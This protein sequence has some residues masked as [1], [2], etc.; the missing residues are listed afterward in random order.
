VSVSHERAP[1]IRPPREWLIP[2]G[3]ALATC[4][5]FGPVLQADFVSWDDDQNFLANPGYRGLGLDQLRWMWSTFHMGHYV[6]LTW[7]THGLDYAFWGMSP[8][9]YHA[10]NLALHAL[11]A[12]LLY[13]LGQRLVRLAGPD[14]EAPAVASSA[15]VAALFFAL[16]PLRVES[17][18]WVTERRDVLSLA[19]YLTAVLSYLRFA[20][21]HATGARRRWYT[22]AVAAGVC[23]VLSKGIAVTLP[24]VLFILNVYPLR[25]LGRASGWRGADARRVYL[26]MAPFAIVAAAMSALSIV[27]LDPGKQL[28]AAEKLA[29]SAYSIAFYLW[30]TIAPSNLSPLYGMPARVD[31][32]AARYVA[33]VALV[34][35]ISI[36]AWLWR[37]R[38]PAFAAVWLAFLAIVFPLLGVV[39]NGPQIA[40]DR[41]TYHAS[42]ALA[43]GLGAA[44][45]LLPARLALGGRALAALL[46]VGLGVLTWRQ[47]RHWHDSER[48]WT[49][50]LAVDPGSSLAHTALANVLI[51]Q[52]RV[53]DAIEHYR[54]VLELDPESRE[55]DNNLGVAYARKG[56]FR[57]AIEQY[58]RAIAKDSAN[59]EANNNLGTAY[60]RLGQHDQAI[61][62]YQAALRANPRFGL[63]QVNWGNAL[64]RLGRLDQAI[65]HY[66]A[67]VALRADDLDAHLNWGVALAQQGRFAEAITHFAQVLERDPNHADARIYLDRATSL[68]RTNP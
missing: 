45:F 42:P 51:R 61:E 9:G 2:I 56:Q 14:A 57:E 17:V 13:F 64:V 66:R 43:L 10:V 39:Q 32:L 25:R 63:A 4:L 54:R 58:R 50:V 35:A 33:S 49:R 15:A 28:G 23:A 53:D 6:P 34:I 20:A 16:H 3:I 44:L 38:A 41:Y 40:A 60:A 5:F 36:A 52:N 27:A 31:P 1:G 26:E 29:V 22:I 55:G 68:K 67:A 11:N 8:R 12:V 37:R 18:A 24:A 48:L 30:K 7:M 19:F 47:T 65:E 59:Y 62:H 46:L 21:A